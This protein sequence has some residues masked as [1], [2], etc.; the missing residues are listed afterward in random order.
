MVWPKNGIIYYRWKCSSTTILFSCF[1]ESGQTDFSKTFLEIICATVAQ[2]N[3]QGAGGGALGLSQLGIRA[4]MFFVQ[5]I[6]IPVQ[7]RP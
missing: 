3:E 4:A 2:W 1:S 6:I 5:R 7:S